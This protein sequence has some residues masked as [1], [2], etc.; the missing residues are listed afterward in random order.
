MSAY[1]IVSIEDIS[2]KE[3]YSRY[4]REVPAIVGEY[5]GK[6]IARGGEVVPFAGEWNPKRVIIIEFPSLDAAREC[7]NSPE[8]RA[9][10]PFREESTITRAIFVEGL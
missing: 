6:Y 4:V 2:D 8:Y 10:A 1:M 5:G 3:R 9:I 7:F